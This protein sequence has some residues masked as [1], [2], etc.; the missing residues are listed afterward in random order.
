MACIKWGSELPLDTVGYL[1]RYGMEN[2]LWRTVVNN[3]SAR[4][5]EFI[6][7]PKDGLWATYLT[8]EMWKVHPLRHSHCTLFELLNEKLEIVLR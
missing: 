3:N 8:R 6:F 7:D 5:H 1:S 4:F 2:S